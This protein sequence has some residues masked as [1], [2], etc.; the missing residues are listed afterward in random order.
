MACRRNAE[1]GK[2]AFQAW[3][4]RGWSPSCGGK[5]AKGGGVEFG[6]LK[7]G[8]KKE[9]RSTLST[10]IA[11]EAPSCGALGFPTSKALIDA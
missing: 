8:E 3:L 10:S 4:G 9:R 1:K 7:M 5:A 6:L 11:R 2:K